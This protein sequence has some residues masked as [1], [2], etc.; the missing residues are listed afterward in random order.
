LATEDSNPELENYL[1][2]TNLTSDALAADRATKFLPIIVAQGFFVGAIAV[3]IAKI[4]STS[5]IPANLFINVEA[6]SIAFSALYFWIL[7]AVF[8]SSIIGVSQTQNAVPRILRR[9]QTG[10]DLELRPTPGRPKVAALP[11]HFLDNHHT[12]LVN[13]GIYSWLPA[14]PSRYDSH[15]PMPLLRRNALPIL[16]VVAGTITAMLVSGNVPPSGWQPRHCAQAMLLLIWLLSFALT[17]L[18]K[19]YTSSRTYNM[20]GRFWLTFA[21]D[22]LATAAT[23]GGIVVTQLGVFNRCDSYALWGRVGLALPEM[24]DAAAV[25]EQRI[26]GL[27]PAIVFVSIGLQMFVVPVVIAVWYRH[28]LL[29]FLQRDDED[30]GFWRRWKWLRLRHNGAQHLGRRDLG[31]GDERTGIAALPKNGMKFE[32]VELIAGGREGS[33]CY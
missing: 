8:L 10:F 2:L 20:S 13:G 18:L 5:P 22:V 9:L 26:R 7:P 1:R 31:Y 27:Y 6:H 16:F 4:T 28:A 32:E 21:K 14:Q 29:V 24:P 23:M 30:A 12:R 25:L 19:R 17:C 11:N 3:A 33:V 15:R